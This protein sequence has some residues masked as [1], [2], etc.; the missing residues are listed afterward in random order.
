MVAFD[1]RH[2]RFDECFE[3]PPARRIV[4]ADSKLADIKA[5]EI[6]ARHAICSV[7]RVCDACLLL[8]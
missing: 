7:E 1:C 6:E 5:E 3:I 2:A 8:A 4:F